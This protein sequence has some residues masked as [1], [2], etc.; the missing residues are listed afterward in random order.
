MGEVGN[1]VELVEGAAVEERR[2]R[3]TIELE[4]RGWGGGDAA[5]G[6]REKVLGITGAAREARHHRLSR[7]AE[8]C[9]RIANLGDL[10]PP[11]IDPIDVKDEPHDP[12]VVGRLS[13]ALDQVV[14]SMP[15]AEDQSQRHGSNLDFRFLELGRNVEHQHRARRD[16][17]ARGPEPDSGE[18][19]QRAYDGD[20]QQNDPH[21][22]PNGHP[23]TSRA[24]RAKKLEDSTQVE[25]EVKAAR[26]LR[27]INMPLESRRGEEAQPQGAGEGLVREHSDLGK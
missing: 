23:G 4:H 19:D 21:A 8:A 9:D 22:T 15:V 14:E 6:G 7:V 24:S 27:G 2:C 18:E 25:R 10:G 20:Q 1:D 11:P 12:I 13:Q 17:D 3:E 16:R 5:R 26:I